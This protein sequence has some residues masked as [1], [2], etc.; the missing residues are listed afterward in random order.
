M[1]QLEAIDVSSEYENIRN[2]PALFYLSLVSASIIGKPP[3]E[4]QLPEGI[5]KS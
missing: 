2:N 5:G 4:T 1:E 3:L